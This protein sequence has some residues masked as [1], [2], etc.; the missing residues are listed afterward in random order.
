MLIPCCSYEIFGDIQGLNILS[1]THS[2]SVSLEGLQ[3]S[4]VYLPKTTTCSMTDSLSQMQHCIHTFRE[5]SAE[6]QGL[7]LSY[8]L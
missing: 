8:F 5:T 2:I 6:M 7:C 1:Q 4:L 3:D